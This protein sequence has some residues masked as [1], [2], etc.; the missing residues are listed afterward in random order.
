M[1]SPFLSLE[2]R[3]APT[4]SDLRVVIAELLA[5]NGASGRLR[6]V[7]SQ[8]W[9]STAA[10][11]GHERELATAWARETHRR[12]SP[13]SPVAVLRYREL[14]SAAAGASSTSASLITNFAFGLVPD[15]QAPRTLARRVFRLRSP[16]SQL[17][18]RD[19]RF[20]GAVMPG[21]IKPFELAP[22]QTA[23]VQPLR[24]DQRPAT[25]PPA[26]TATTWPWGLAGLRASIRFTD[27]GEGVAGRVIASD[28]DGIALWWQGLHHA[29]QY[30]SALGV[31]PA[32][33]LPPDFRSP[34]IRGFLPVLPDPPLPALDA[35]ALF[36][37]ATGAWRQPVLPGSIR[38]TVVGA[39]PGAFLSLRPQLTRQSGLDAA[40][41]GQQRGT[42]LT[43]GSV[44]VQHRAPRPIS[45]P[46]NDP[47]DLEHALQPWASWFEPQRGL[48]A[49]TEPTDE[50]F[51]AATGTQP[52]HRLQIKL[53]SPARG[54]IETTWNG[55]IIAD[56]TFDGPQATFDEWN[57]SVEL[58][59]GGHTVPY[60]VAPPASRGAGRYTFHPRGA[61]ATSPIPQAL[62]DLL[63]TL[64]P[65]DL[66]ELTSR[67]TRAAGADGFFQRLSLPMRA[68]DLG[69]PSR[70]PLE[71]F[72]VLF[73]D[74]EYNRLLSS[75]S[76]NSS[77]LVK[78]VAGGQL[79]MRLVTLAAD[80]AEYDPSAQ[81]AVRYDWEDDRSHP[82]E[83]SIDLVDLAGL[84][85]PLTLLGA[86][87]IALQAHTL[88]VFPLA[89]LRDGEAPAQLADGDTL[90]LK[91]RIPV[92]AGAIV[93]EASIVVAAGIVSR[94]VTPVPQAAYA[95]LRRQVVAS[96]AQVECVRFAWSPPPTRVELVCPEDL[97]TGMVRRRA[98]FLWTDTARTATAT[99]FAVQKLTLSGSTHFPEPSELERT[100]ASF[101][102]S[103]RTSKR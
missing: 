21:A 25:M 26:S 92:S 81:L 11:A 40:A 14:R 18:F 55:V 31:D 2:L 19:G 54:Q 99:G 78:T 59:R 98:V 39:R 64:A 77:G 62:F 43:S 34:P 28:Q 42:A 97:R 4:A 60:D 65:G 83:L 17:R 71:P 61:A 51:F 3:P 48:V 103:S 33:G 29:V 32:A 100:H 36:P 75:P 41:P 96:Q 9:E 46:P 44:P 20:G 89:A 16:V 35:A 63:S 68:V 74:P 15:V 5:I 50:S 52:A 56:L 84:A 6:P 49:R 12:L 27:H 1:V 91:L 66:V 79:T 53:I 45:L 7:A 95:L 24:L 93:E 38:A 22:P 76:N 80:R 57:V 94:P 8:S 73:E 37:A 85:R 86:R 102:V 72:F 82:A 90:L 67:V 23:G 58:V 10:I 101:S 87:A 88:K 70:L 47:A 13:E 30:R 69:A